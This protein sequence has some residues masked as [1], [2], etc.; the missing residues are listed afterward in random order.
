[1]QS[2]LNSFESADILNGFQNVQYICI[3]IFLKY[4]YLNTFEN[5]HLNILKV[6]EYLCHISSVFS[7]S[8]FWKHWKHFF[9]HCSVFVLE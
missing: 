5:L 7:L 2:Y 8:T 4:S 3:Q 1:M 6:F 9:K